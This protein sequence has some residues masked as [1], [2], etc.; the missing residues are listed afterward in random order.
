ML[1]PLFL[2]NI[3]YDRFEKIH[4]GAHGSVSY[5]KIQS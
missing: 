2:K 3:H 4:D 1:R 5:E